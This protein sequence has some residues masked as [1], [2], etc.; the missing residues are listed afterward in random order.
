MRQVL[1]AIP[2]ILNIHIQA[3]VRAGAAEQ[4]EIPLVNRDLLAQLRE[5]DNDHAD[6]LAAQAGRRAGH[7]ARLAHLAGGEHVAELAV[8]EP[9]I[10]LAV[11]A[12]RHIRWCIGIERPS[13]AEEVSCIAHESGSTADLSGGGIA[14][15][16]AGQRG[17][18]RALERRALLAGQAARL[19]GGRYT[20]GG[21]A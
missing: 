1:L 11:G 21:G 2:P 9:I 18:N 16:A 13:S 3:Q 6:A 12:A 8:G 10:Q 7:E 14:Q 17:A 19:N 15:L 5:V 20:A 4:A